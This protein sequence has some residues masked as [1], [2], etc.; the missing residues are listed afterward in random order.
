MSGENV[1]LI[2]L[3]LFLLAVLIALMAPTP[4]FCSRCGQPGIDGYLY[5]G[6]WHEYSLF[7][8][9]CITHDNYCESCANFLMDE[10]SERTRCDCNPNGP[11]S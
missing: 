5:E 7:S 4:I 8:E 6:I 2:L 3:I 10:A 9:V 1:L 11:G